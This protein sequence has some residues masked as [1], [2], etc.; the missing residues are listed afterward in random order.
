MLLRAFN[1]KAKFLFLFIKEKNKK[2]KGKNQ[3]R[4]NSLFVL[5]AYLTD[6]LSMINFLV[7]TEDK[8]VIIFIAHLKVLAMNMKSERWTQRIDC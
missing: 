8:T 5:M 6:M 2:Q 1:I 3:G 4:I 7:H